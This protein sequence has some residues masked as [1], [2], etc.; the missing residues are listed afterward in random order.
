MKKT[1]IISLI[2]IFALVFAVAA[3][4]KNAVPAITGESSHTEKEI[5]PGVI[6]AE[7]NTPSTNS[8][9]KTQHI[10]VLKFDLKQRDLYL[11]TFYYN[12]SATKLS[13]VANDITQYNSTHTDKHAIAAVNGDMWMV[14]YSQARIEGKEHTNAAMQGYTDD[15]VKKEMTVSRSYNVVD[16]EIYTSGTI[17]Q[18]TPYAGPSWAFGITDDFVPVL[19]QPTVDITATDKT[20]GKSIKIDGINR[21]PAKDAIIMYTDRLMGSLT[22]FALDSSYEI[23]LEFDA[24]YTPA[25]GMNVTGTVKAIYGP[26]DAANPGKLNEKQMVLTSRGTTVSKLKQF[27]IGDKINI[28]VSVGDIQGNDEKWQRVQSSIGGNIVYIKNGVLTGNGIESGYPTTMLGYDKEGKI[29]M[30]TMDGRNKGGAGA[31]AARYVQLIK[32]LD[33][34]EAFILDGGG[35]MTMVVSDSADYTSYKM[36][37][38]PTDSGGARTVNNAFVLAYGPE[39]A[40]QGEIEIEL[41]AEITDPTNIEFPTKAYVTSLV[42]TTNEAT[43]GWE[44]GCLKLTVKNFNTAP[45]MA[46]PFAAFSY[47]GVTNKASANTYKYITYIYKIPETNSRASYSS[48][49]FCQC[50]G[51]GAEGG[52][53]T[54]ATVK[55]TGQFEYVTFNASNL[56]K[57]KGTITGLRLDFFYGAM[58]EGDCMYIHNILLSETKVIGDEK[59]AKI[60]E[61]LNTVEIPIIPGDANRDGVVNNKDVVALFRIV[62]EDTVTDIPTE[63]LDFNGDGKVNNKDVTALFREISK[64]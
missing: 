10:N 49:V 1:R 48:E 27:A 4:A 46:D 18:D 25:H 36:V 57:W 53:S 63:V 32:D 54:Q 34:Y 47:Q 19:G 61:K 39:R 21:L 33:L 30:I 23:L 37:S 64:T 11:D 60:A 52:Q 35:S 12:K 6:H 26:D 29:L 58:A 38:T 24:D 3:A 22:G 42:S 31:T 43:A 15:V 45:G 62:S 17:K 7:I 50:E 51:R 56:S 14:A 28:T 41:P 8:T 59:G 55:R 44:D 9:Y 5:Y 13:T 20:N 16:G 2:L 40:E